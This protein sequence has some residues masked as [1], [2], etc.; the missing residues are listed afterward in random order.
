M[1][2]NLSSLKGGGCIEGVYWGLPMGLLRGIQKKIDYS[3]YGL[4]V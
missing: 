1:S 4:P 2:Y 3:S